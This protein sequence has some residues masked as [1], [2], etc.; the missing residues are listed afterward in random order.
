MHHDMHVS[1]N[2]LDCQLRKLGARSVFTVR[3]QQAWAASHWVNSPHGLVSW[4]CC[5]KVPHTESLK[6]S[7]VGFLPVL[8]ARSLE[9]KGQQGWFSLEAPKETTALSWGL[10]MAGGP[11]GPLAQRH[12]TL[13]SALLSHGFLFSVGLCPLFPLFIGTL[14]TALGLILLQCEHLLYWSHLW[15]RG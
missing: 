13:V 15:M 3:K 11:Q 9:W 5:H 6:I 8:E 14:G 12:I 7:K 4:G 2:N 1:E 10:P